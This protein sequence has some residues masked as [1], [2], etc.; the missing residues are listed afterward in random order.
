MQ[1]TR[2]LPAS[3]CSWGLFRGLFDPARGGAD[4]RGRAADRASETSPAPAARRRLRLRGA[5]RRLRDQDSDGPGPIGTTGPR[6]TKPPF[7]CR[8]A[9][10]SQQDAEILAG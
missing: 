4:L 2:T 1:G 3:S 9:A 7:F 5:V 10:N 8:T 6:S